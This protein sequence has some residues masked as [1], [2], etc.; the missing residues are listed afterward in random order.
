V[1][2]LYLCNDLFRNG[3]DCCGCTTCESPGT[4][5]IASPQ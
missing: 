4:I 5:N 1:A 3:S 2:A